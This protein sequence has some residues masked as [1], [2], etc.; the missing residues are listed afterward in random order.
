MLPEKEQQLLPSSP[1]VVRNGALYGALA[2]LI[3]TWSISTA[4]A[5]SELELQLPMGTFYAVIGTSL[6]VA[7]DSQLG[8]YAGFGLHLM[9]GT[10]LVAA[11]G[12]VAARFAPRS[13]L[14]PYRSLAFGLAAGMAVWLALPLNWSKR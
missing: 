8:A 5:A 9:T 4:I 11:I 10:A 7:G 13:L 12:A 6:G 14:S 2:G 3:A 1:R